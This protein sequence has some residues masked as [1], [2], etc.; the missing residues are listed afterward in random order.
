MHSLFPTVLMFY[1]QAGNAASALRDI[2]LRSLVSAS[3]S[4]RVPLFHDVNRR[5]YTHAKLVRMFRAAMS[6]C[7][8]KA[9]AA[10]YTWNSYRS[11]MATALHAAGVDDVRIQLIRKW[12]SPASLHV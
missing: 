11:R 12:L 9:A 5:P 6:M 2:E 7:F 1:H 3:Q 8:G 10:A 4:L